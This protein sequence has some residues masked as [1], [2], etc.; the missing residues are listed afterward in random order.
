MHMRLTTVLTLAMAGP[1]VAGEHP[2]TPNAIPL[3]RPAMK[4]ALEDL[5]GRKPRIPLPELTEEEK[6]KLGERGANYES[7]L[8]YHYLHGGEGRGGGL[9]S[10]EPDPNMSLDYAFKTELFW[11]VSRTNNC[12]Y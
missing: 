2:P 10:R 8:R 5:K 3:T 12:H 6:E 4:Q 1:L 9:F 7:R 11:I